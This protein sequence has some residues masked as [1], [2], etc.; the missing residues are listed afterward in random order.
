MRIRRSD[1]AILSLGASALVTFTADW[2]RAAHE[3]QRIWTVVSLAVDNTAEATAA[4][5]LYSDGA[6]KVA[7]LAKTT[8]R[9]HR[10]C[11]ARLRNLLGE[12][13]TGGEGKE[14]GCFSLEQVR[15]SC[16]GSW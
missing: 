10:L 15:N 9:D 7:V 3:R 2:T 4:G 12:Q 16:L 13:R 5:A 6:G 14:Q 11:R 1:S 8:Q